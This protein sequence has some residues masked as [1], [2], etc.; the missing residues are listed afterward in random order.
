MKRIG[1]EEAINTI[2][3]SMAKSDN[4]GCVKSWIVR[5]KTGRP[6]R[7]S[8]LVNHGAFYRSRVGHSDFSAAG[9]QSI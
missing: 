7:I 9:S 1:R 5:P 3:Q 2:V 8:Y 4:I 6:Y